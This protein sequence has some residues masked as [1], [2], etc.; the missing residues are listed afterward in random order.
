MKKIS[1]F[2][3][4][5]LLIAC[6]KKTE[7]Q[8]IKFKACCGMEEKYGLMT[9]KISSDDV[10]L[11]VGGADI[12]MTLQDTGNSRA[13]NQHIGW[14]GV[15]PETNKEL[16]VYG[17]YNTE[18]KELEIYSFTEENH[19]YSIDVVFYA[20]LA[21]FTPP[22]ESEKCIEEIR[23][24]TV[25]S[26]KNVFVEKQSKVCGTR[27]DNDDCRPDN[28]YSLIEPTD[29]VKISQ[30]WA[31][32]DFVEYSIDKEKKYKT[33]PCDALSNLKKYIEEH[34]SETEQVLYEED[35]LCHAGSNDIYVICD[36]DDYNSFYYKI[37]LCNNGI[38]TLT[39]YHIFGSRIFDD[40]K[41]LLS[42]SQT[43]NGVLYSMEYVYPTEKKDILYNNNSVVLS[44]PYRDNKP[45]VCEVVD[46]LAQ[47]QICARVI[48]KRVKQDSVAGTVEM[49]MRYNYDSK[50]QKHETKTVT[51]S[52]E[53]ALSVS[54]NW[55][56]AN[57]IKAYKYGTEAYESDACVVNERLND[58]YN[59]II[60]E[61]EEKK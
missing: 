23:S 39:E 17:N 7:Y 43:E 57:G 27:I 47:H 59:K 22:T 42:A 45:V 19:N 11:N 31:P 18:T 6:D 44:Y 25:T 35:K 3:L 51:L 28:Y 24:L 46:E 40:S 49:E 56:Y 52:A 33:E 38:Q 2:I 13:I 1:A 12:K 58:M 14:T 41:Y 55:D 21:G 4:P 48:D 50:T 34:K 10:M 8:E 54:P 16:F 15:L 30:N 9:L 37:S 36:T 20:D 26:F 29:A 5:L 53:Q 32:E 61:L 60:D